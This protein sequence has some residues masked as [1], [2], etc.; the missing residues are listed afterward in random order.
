MA[1]SNQA[2][3]SNL[4]VLREAIAR[5]A[6]IVL[7]LP[8]AGLLRHHK[9]RFLTDAGDG[10][11]VESVPTERPLIDELIATQK[12]S[13]VSFKGGHRKIVLASPIQYRLDKYRVNADTVVEA[14]LLPFPQQ[15]QAIQRRTNYRV[16]VFADFGLSV[17]VW[18]IAEQ[19]HL[20]DRPMDAVSVAAQVR[21][22]SLGGLGVTFTGNNGEPP[23]VSAEDRL[24]I[25]LT[26]KDMVLLLEG[27]MR[28]ATPP[29]SGTIARAGLQ[30]K[31]LDT[32]LE[33]RQK[34]AQLTR[35]VGE[36]QREEVR[37]AR[38]SA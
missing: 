13:G 35:I 21:D 12:P 26:Y 34:L 22:V 5:N 10:F 38:T 9:S 24:R 18:R 28:H 11:L 16:R 31:P 4:E 19:A 14:L 30:F 32:H 29:A 3:Q 33:G 27:R 2:N 6:A 36:L 1:E 23:K 20:A 7:S 8:S 15:I 37:R 25:E 17:H